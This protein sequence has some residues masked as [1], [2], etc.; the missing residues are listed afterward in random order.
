MRLYPFRKAHKMNMSKEQ[1][2]FFIENSKLLA[3]AITTIALM[4]NPG[5][6]KS[7]RMSIASVAV[8]SFSQEDK[9]LILEQAAIEFNNIETK[10]GEHEES[11]SV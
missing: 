6:D 10:K 11:R 3:E 4:N 1:Q 8:D 7:Y 5:E 2:E 9:H